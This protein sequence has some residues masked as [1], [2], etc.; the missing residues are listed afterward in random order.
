MVNISPKNHIIKNVQDNPLELPVLIHVI[1]CGNPQ[2]ANK[3][4]PIIP[5]NSSIMSPI[6]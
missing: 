5:D 2:N 6:I 1:A 4:A 3:T